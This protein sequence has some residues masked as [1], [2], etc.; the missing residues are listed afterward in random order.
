[1][2]KNKAAQ[3]LVD[4]DLLDQ[5]YGFAYKRC[6]S[7]HE[8]E[9]LTSE[10][11]LAILRGLDRAERIEHFHAFIWTIARRTYADYCARRSRHRS[12]MGGE[13]VDELLH[14][15]TDP[16]DDFIEQEGAAAQL[17]LIKREISFLSKSY[18]D[19]MIMYYLDKMS[20]AQISAQLGISEN[21]VK[22]RLY[23][24]RH[25]I[26]NEVGK[27]KETNIALKPME[28]IFS[29]AGEPVGNDPRIHATRT[30]SQNIIYLCKNTARTAKQLAEL[31]NVPMAIIEEE[32]DIQCR[33]QNGR[34]GL[35]Q[36]LDHGKYISNFMMIDA[37]DYNAIYK[38]YAVQITDLVEEM[39]SYLHENKA[40]IINIRY[41]NNKI[42]VKSISWLLIHSMFWQYEE[43]VSRI[44]REQY[45]TNI[46]PVKREFNVFGFAVKKG[47][48]LDLDFYGCDGNQ[49]FDVSGYASVFYA[50]LYGKH[51]EKHFSCGHDLSRD[52]MLQLTIKAIDGKALSRLTADEKEV[53][54]KAIKEGYIEQENG[55]LYPKI[56][57]LDADGHKKFARLA[58]DFGER[59]LDLA[60]A[61]A[62]LIYE[63]FSNYA[64]AHL[65][66]EYEQF[67]THTMAGILSDVYDQCIEKRLIN[68]PETK[69]SAEGTWMVVTK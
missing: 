51:L 30:L 67:V 63:C 53:A 57:V 6:N 59:T 44:L 24:A 47:E 2:K 28:L 45:F 49:A 35:L 7:S 3:R 38:K 41:L 52:A 9:D 62:Q 25:T 19:V 10:M 39:A 1:M 27:M 65:I 17:Q 54:A 56:V 4:K 43:Q 13:Y 42:D 40:D 55:I 26:R 58:K 21:A 60:G 48:Q 50:N 16:I 37:A 15:Q 69:P 22:Q 36:K 34:Y 11:I 46:E 12:A 18:R 23:T 61:A 29:G 14:F 5:L 8:A 31:L 20:I 32:L 68:I 66:A 33:G 64:P